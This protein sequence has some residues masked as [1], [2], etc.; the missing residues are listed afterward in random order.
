MQIT[1]SASRTGLG[2]SLTMGGYKLAGG[3]LP[4][5]YTPQFLVGLLKTTESVLEHRYGPFLNK[6]ELSGLLIRR[7]VLLLDALQ[8]GFLRLIN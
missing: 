6:A 1:P 5:R 3:S 8:R 4:D 7:R 2:R